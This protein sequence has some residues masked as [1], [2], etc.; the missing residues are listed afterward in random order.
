VNFGLAAGSD[1]YGSLRNS[2]SPRM[3]YLFVE[4]RREVGRYSW[5]QARGLVIS[6]SFNGAKILPPT[7]TNL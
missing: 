2:Y 6:D 5:T 4:T 7:S 3:L 1:E